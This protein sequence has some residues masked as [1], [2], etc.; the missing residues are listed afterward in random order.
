M[1]RIVSRLVSES[2]FGLIAR[3]LATLLAIVALLIP[4]GLVAPASEAKIPDVSV[5]GVAGS[6]PPGDCW[7]CSAKEVQGLTLWIGDEN[8][9]RLLNCTPGQPLQAAYVWADIKINP[10]DRYEALARFQLLV[11]STTVYSGVVCFSDAMSGSG[12]YKLMAV[13]GSPVCGDSI[14]LRNL[15]IGWHTQGHTDGKCPDSDDC[16]GPNSKCDTIGDTSVVM[17]L[18]ATFM[19]RRDCNQRVSF[20]DTVSGGIEPYT[21]SWD[22]GDGGT[23]TQ[24]DPTHVYSAAGTYTVTLTVTDAA[25]TVST[26][27]QQVVVPEVVDVSIAASPGLTLMCGTGTVT[28]TASASGG[29]GD[30][31]YAWDGPDA[32]S[33]YDDGTG[34]VLTVS[35]VG[36]YSVLATDEAGCTDT[37]S[38]TVVAEYPAPQVAIQKVVDQP[39]V[40]AD[41]S[42]NYTYLVTNTGDCPLL[43]VAVTD[44]KLGAISLA[45]LTDQDGDATAD[46]LAAG[47]SATGTASA[48]ILADTT[49]VAT[50]TGH[51]GDGTPASAQGSASVTVYR[52]A[53]SL[54]KVGSTT[55][56]YINDTINYTLTVQ[57]TGDVALSNVTVVDQK[58]GISQSIE[59]LAPGASQSVFGSYLVTE[60]DLG[61]VSNTATAD[62]NETDPVT[63]TWN[64]TVTPRPALAIAKLADR[65]VAHIGDTV[66]YTITVENIGDVTLHNVVVSDVLLGIATTYATLPV[67]VPRS[68]YGSYLVTEADLNGISNTAT[69]DSA[70][71]E[72]VSDSWDVTVVAQPGLSITKTGDRETANIGDTIQYTIVVRNTGDVTLHNVTVVDAKL[73]I[74]QTI[75][76]LAPSA[77]QSFSG[78]YVVTEADLGGV[79]NTA[80]ADSDETDAVSD[81]WDVTVVAQPGLSITK[82]GDRET[83]NIGDTIQYTI[84]VRNTGDV[85]LHNVTVVDAKLGINQTIASLAP[86]ASQS[87]SGSYVVTEA[88]VEEGVVHNTAYASSEG[89]GEVE[90]GVD[91]EVLGLGL[92]LTKT[93]DRESAAVGDVI[94]YTIVVQNT[95]EA[96]LEDVRVVDAMLGIDTSVGGLEP[97]ATATLTG[98]YTVQESD[99]PGPLVNTAVATGGELRAEDSAT[100]ALEEPTPTPTATPET[101]VPTPT[102]TTTPP[103]PCVRSDLSVLIYGGWGGIPVNASV[104]GTGQDTQYT[105]QD[106]SGTP[107]VLWTFY[108]AEGEVLN[109]V[110]TPQLPAGLDPNEW[111]F[112]PASASTS[113]RRCQNRQ[114]VFR[115]V[116][117]TPPPEELLLPVT[118][119]RGGVLEMVAVWWQSL[120]AWCRR[121]LGQ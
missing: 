68:V 118:G 16:P 46:D 109:V 51:S 43:D 36:T 53:L 71:T 48:V 65:T 50:V 37:A 6:P 59:S 107:A 115:L 84:V 20:D 72:A 56:A 86:N 21:R 121:L 27:T 42:V 31:T 58:L 111:K 89:A 110:V 104:G 81:S 8:G 34:Q 30:I 88:D 114:L 19:A 41:T 54:T 82:T 108:P 5:S 40:F 93:A 100:V 38:A 29:T 83:A 14:L 112:E 79:S 49:N 22:F 13:P 52:P 44:D 94:N 87:F 73:G 33:D 74:N 117:T 119:A 26:F 28:L 92:S 10:S 45:G 97:G 60:A 95:G 57:N 90:D 39:Y 99:L 85:T 15:Q 11:N 78:S 4:G 1:P 98:T 55:E 67:G 17:P 66:H 102:P 35:A 77:S 75:A 12:S 23:S 101:P 47:A 96:T 69:A 103:P 64:V 61:G 91:V 113:I 120:V 80:I 106:S 9:N 7:K 18:A 25:S 63:A 76:S 62:S 2:R 3:R 105:A 70:E 32:D 24:E 116:H